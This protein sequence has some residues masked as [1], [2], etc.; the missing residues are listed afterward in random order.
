MGHCLVPVSFFF[1]NYQELL[2]RCSGLSRGRGLRDANITKRDSRY[3]D[4]RYRNSRYKE[5]KP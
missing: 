4:S 3:R 1:A 5:G 2:R